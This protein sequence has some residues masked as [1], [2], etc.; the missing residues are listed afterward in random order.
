M[1]FMEM[2]LLIVKTWHDLHPHNKTAEQMN[3]KL[4]KAAAPANA[5][6]M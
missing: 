6:K 3:Y 2:R 5:S 4:Y 1:R